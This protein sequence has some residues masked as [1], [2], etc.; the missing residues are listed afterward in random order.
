MS[1]LQS[2]LVKERLRQAEN[3]ALIRDLRART[4]EL[5]EVSSSHEQLSLNED[6]VSSYLQA[7]L[8]KERL[9]QAE[10]DVLIRDLR[11]Q[12]QELEQVCSLQSLR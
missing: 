2:Q 4:Q 11:A 9:R 3:D 1:C 8:V 12:I 6:S 5:E 10:N 7:Q